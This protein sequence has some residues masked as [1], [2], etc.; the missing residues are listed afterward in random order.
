MPTQGF[1]LSQFSRAP[2]VPGNIGVVDTKSIYGSVVDALKSFEAARTAQQ[3]QAATDAELALATQKAATEQALL[4]PESEARRARAN[5]LASEAVAAMPGVDVA[6]R[7]KRAADIL[8]SAT[9][10]SSLSLVP[11]RTATEK[12][13]LGAERV[14][15]TVL[16]DED[17]VRRQQQYKSLGTAG[18]AR[19]RNLDILADPN[20]APFA[21]QAAAIA[22]GIE[23]KAVAPGIGYQVLTDANGNQRL[24]ATNKAAVGAMD[25][26]TGQMV[27]GIAPGTRPTM[28][29]SQLSLLPNQ[30]QPSAAPA[31]AAPAAPATPAP[32]AGAA[33][34]TPTVQAAPR[35][36]TD[37]IWLGQSAGEK[38]TQQDISQ[39]KSEW[40]KKLP[41]LESAIR[42]METK[43]ARD[44]KALEEAENRLSA[45]NTGIVGQAL[46]GFGGTEALDLVELL[47]PVRTNIFTAELDQMRA[48]SPT[49]GAVGNVTDVEGNKFESALGSLDTAQ[50]KGQLLDQIE[51]VRNARREVLNNMK[52]TVEEYRRYLGGFGGQTAAQPTLEE[53]MAAYR[54]R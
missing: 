13:K 2:Q 7:A 23:P 26:V 22:L 3:V 48:N 29:P 8:S 20:A 21:R 14:L 49:G 42:S 17:L 5:L 44:E 51:N 25:V 24:V 50:S 45:F 4:T 35:P 52:K 27:G 9:S 28:A 12:A 33:P 10:E 15:G 11:D 43:V 37:N 54:N 39:I 53:R 19:Q 31:A 46:R 1:Q 40:F 6:A 18:A 38:A 36:T 32:A 41:A 47:K 30:V 16:S 34:L